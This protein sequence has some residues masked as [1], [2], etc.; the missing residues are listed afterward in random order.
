MILMKLFALLGAIV[1]LGV[2]ILGVLT[3]ADYVMGNKDNRN[4]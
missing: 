3:L 4:D 2:I 1:I